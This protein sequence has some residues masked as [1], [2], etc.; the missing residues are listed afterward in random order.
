MKNETG[1]SQTNGALR[2]SQLVVMYVPAQLCRSKF[3]VNH[4]VNIDT[5]QQNLIQMHCYPAE[6]F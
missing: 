5:C 1:A 2:Q 6:L 4:L 3:T